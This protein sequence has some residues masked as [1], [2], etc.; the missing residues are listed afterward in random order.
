MPVLYYYCD[1]YPKHR[2]Y[3]FFTFLTFFSYWKTADIIILNETHW[4]DLSQNTVYLVIL[5]S[6]ICIMKLGEK[7]YI[8]SNYIN[9]VVKRRINS[10]AP[11]VS[12]ISNNLENTVCFKLDLKKI[13]LFLYNAHTL[14]LTLV[15]QQHRITRWIWRIICLS[16]SQ[17]CWLL[18]Q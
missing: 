5:S 3:T 18:K 6:L 8:R 16:I 14:S 9:V 2:S 12:Y 11:L 13:S 15:Y 1:F 10:N 17:S 7:I 4:Q